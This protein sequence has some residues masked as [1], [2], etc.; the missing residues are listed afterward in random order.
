MKLPDVMPQGGPQLAAYLNGARFAAYS[1]FWSGISVGLTNLGSGICVGIAGS[2]CAIA[3]AQDASLF[4]KILMCVGPP[5]RRP[6]PRYAPRSLAHAPPNT[7]PQRSVEIFGSAL[8]LFGVIVAIIQSNA[9][10]FP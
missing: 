8:G 7:P 3:D 1:I 10:D 4:V 2:S 5:P 9:S 6:R